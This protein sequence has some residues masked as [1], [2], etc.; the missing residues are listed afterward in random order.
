MNIHATEGAPEWDT[1][2]ALAG[3]WRLYTINFLVIGVP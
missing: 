2:R 3:V 1:K